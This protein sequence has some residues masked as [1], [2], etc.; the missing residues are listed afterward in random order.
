MEIKFENV[1]Y[2]YTKINYEEKKV[3][4]NINFSVK[5]GTINSIIG[6]NGCGKTTLLELISL[7]IKP[8]NGKIKIDQVTITNKTENLE[9]VRKK[10]GYI[11]QVPIEQFFCDTVYQE[12]KSILQMNGYKDD[13][14]DKRIH[15]VLLM[16]DLEEEKLISNPNFLS[17]GEMRKLAIAEALILNPKILV[18][19][20][21]TVNLDSKSKSNFIKLI[22][23]LK[24]RYGK[25]IIIASHDMDFVHK[26]SDYIYVLFNQKIVMQGTKYE[27]FKDPQKL[28]KYNLIPPKVMLFS[29]KVLTKKNIK[30]GYRDEINDLLKDI[31]RYV[32]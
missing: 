20:E 4:S 5:T 26:V 10:I 12:L 8:T 2:N 22:R 25:T 1:N 29:D 27:I 16:V 15:D 19:D 3:L 11:S 14:I 23:L 6:P 30:I 28:K 18:L 21:P 31:Y 7:L 9:I 13:H 24:N 32:N 17:H